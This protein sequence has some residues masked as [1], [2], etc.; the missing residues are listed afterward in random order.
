MTARPRPWSPGRERDASRRARTAV[1]LTVLTSVTVMTLDAGTGE[2]S[3]VE[4]ARS[5]ASQVFGPMESGLST[6]SAPVVTG[7]DALVNARR[8]KSDNTRL[9]RE[10]ATLRTGLARSEA[11]R[12]R[13]AQYDA[14][15]AVSE[16]SGFRLVPARVV[17]VGPAQAFARTVTI[18]AGTTDGVR[19]DLTV[20]EAGGLVGRVIRAGAHTATVLLAVDAESV[21][22]G[23]LAE[24]MELGYLRGSG[25]LGGDGLL[26]MNVVDR[27]VD[28]EPG[29]TVVTWGSRGDG[30]YVAGV[31]IG[32]VIDARASAGDQSVTA[33]VEP[34]ADMSSLDLVGV[35]V[36]PQRQKQRSELSRVAP[37]EAADPGGR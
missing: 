14:L 11:D 35:V 5:A 3:P 8:L 29:D 20:V 4:P 2:D 23:R 21:V 24:S 33:R 9:E 28:P 18:D 17:A 34:F 16:S 10:V 1:A 13:L 27:T 22:G 12:N 6:L 36:G 26:H 19:P 15:A 37:A 7:V 32:T 25:D 31:P 30:P